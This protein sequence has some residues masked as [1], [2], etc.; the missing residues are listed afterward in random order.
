METDITREK[1]K[2]KF[3]NLTMKLFLCLYYTILVNKFIQ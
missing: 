3:K 1:T 2:T